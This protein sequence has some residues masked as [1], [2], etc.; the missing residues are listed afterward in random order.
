[1]GV[2]RWEFDGFL[3]LFQSSD[4]EGSPPVVIVNETFAKRAFPQ[5]GAVGRDIKLLSGQEE[6]WRE[7]VAVV[8]DNKY[9]S[10]SEAPEPQV[11]PPYLQTGGRLFVQV[12]TTGAPQPSVP[13]VKSAIAEL[14]K[15]LLVEAQT[16][17]EATSI[18]LTLRRY[19]TML[20][21]AMGA[22]GLL[23]AMVGLFGVLAWEV[24][25]RT[26]EIGL[27]MAL[28]ASR[29]A[30]RTRVVR[31]ALVLVGA[32]TVVGLGGAVGVTLP[33][34]GFLA[35]VSTADP[36]ALGAV[37]GVLLGVAVLASA[38]PAHR[39]SGID[40]ATALRREG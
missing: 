40:P 15:T 27:R 9:T 24:T 7:I 26:P 33:L 38:L 12:R 37:A 36:V 14:D 29:Q 35:G 8:A 22:L 23:L 39:A 13:A 4:R 34:R 5:G 16:T 2:G 6:P 10:L 31:D 32:G 20:L 3:G 28:G 25:H 18:E 21:G 19:A 11:F 30:V 1:L 17:A